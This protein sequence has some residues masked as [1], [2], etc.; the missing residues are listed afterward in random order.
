MPKTKN[1]ERKFGRKPNR[2]FPR[3]TLE[4]AL[5]MAKAITE[6]NAGKPMKRLLLADAI[7]RKPTSIQFRDLLSAS[8]KYGLT[9]G[10]EKAEQI[11]LTNLGRKITK[12]ISPQEEKQ[13]KQ[14][15]VL[16]PEVFK[17]IYSHYKNA[18]FPSGRFFENTLN[19]QFDIPQE[20]VKEIDNLL[21]ENGK[22]VGIIRDISGSPNIIFDDFETKEEVPSEGSDL[23]ETVNENMAEEINLGQERA[24]PTLPQKG[25]LRP[26]FLAHSKNKK[27][28]E[29][30]KSILDQFN[31][32]YKVAVDEPNVG[33]PISKKVEDLMNSC[34]SAIFIFSEEGELHG[35]S[36]EV[37]PNLNGIFELGAAGVLYGE[38]I[39]IFKEENIELPSDLSGLAY[40]SF[41]KNK[42]EAKTMDLLKE[43]VAM[44]FVKIMPA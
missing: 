25:E 44:G 9:L 35:G 19:V 12:P 27:P 33:R 31:I 38:K 7:K 4:Q 3:Y 1:E 15:A 21:Q 39:I 2:P 30:L 8:Y 10:T 13:A 34:S 6:N 18:K 20:Y 22:Y 42:L 29:Q 14:V 11:V 37:I 43:L 17:N 26:I 24:I 36:K 40:I 41:E 5:V 28:L 16:N 23:L 32:P